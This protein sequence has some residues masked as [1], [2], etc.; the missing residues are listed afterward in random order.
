MFKVDCTLCGTNCEVP[1]NPTGG[2]P[3]R[4]SE[5]MQKVED[6]EA[7]QDELAKERELLISQRGAGET[8]YK[9]F[10]GGVPDEASEEE[11]RELFAVHGQLKSVDIATDREGNRRNFAFVKAARAL[12]QSDRRIMRRHVLPNALI[13]SVTML[14][15]QIGMLISGALIL[16]TIFGLPGIGRGLVQAA[17]SRDYPVI[18][19]LATLLVFLSLV[20]N[21]IVDMLYKFI[22]PRVSYSV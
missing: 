9:I 16:E 19:S 21:L 12:G 6:G 10:I 1:F 22:D 8:G 15:L 2:R 18:Q 17:V 4:C 20:V 7:S 11:L 14:G 5:C 13:P 3:V